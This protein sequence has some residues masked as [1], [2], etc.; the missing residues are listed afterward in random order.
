MFFVHLQSHCQWVLV[1]KGLAQDMSFCFASVMYSNVIQS[2]VL[3]VVMWPGKERNDSFLPIILFL[4]LFS[5]PS[6]PAPSSAASP[7]SSVL[8]ILA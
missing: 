7:F 3:I 4:H 8:V 2:I 6:L 1:Y 5:P